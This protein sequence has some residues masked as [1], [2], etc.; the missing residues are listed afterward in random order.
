MGF[1]F[2]GLGIRPIQNWL[3]LA[4]RSPRGASGPGGE[5]EALTEKVPSHTRVPRKYLAGSPGPWSALGLADPS[6]HCREGI[7][8]SA[9]EGLRRVNN[10][11]PLLLN[12]WGVMTALW[13]CLSLLKTGPEILRDERVLRVAFK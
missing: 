10:L 5:P 8:V 11:P 4:S 9:C 6:H 7:E 12:V 1:C 2:C 13:F 3:L